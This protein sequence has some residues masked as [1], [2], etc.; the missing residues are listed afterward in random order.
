MTIVMP[1]YLFGEMV[2]F[3]ILDNTVIAVTDTTCNANTVFSREYDW[4]FDLD[5]SYLNYAT[6]FGMFINSKNAASCYQCLKTVFR[7][8]VQFPIYP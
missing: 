2:T 3:K 1:W 4:H 6:H 8:F 7:Y 5:S